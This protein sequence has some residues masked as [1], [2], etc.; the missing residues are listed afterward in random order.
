MLTNEEQRAYVK[1][2][3]ARN[4]ERYLETKR[5]AWHR[6]ALK[7]KETIRL[8][9]KEYARKQRAELLELRN[10]L[11]NNFCGPT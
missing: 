11:N 3:K 6:Y 4:L 8:A 1:A 10:K 9:R 7:N 2:Y 5:A